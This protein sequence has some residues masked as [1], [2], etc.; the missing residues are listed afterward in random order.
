MPQSRR[1]FGLKLAGA[2]FTALFLATIFVLMWMTAHYRAE[3]DWTT[4]GRNSLSAPSVALLRRLHRPV[5][6]RA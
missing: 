1:R 6:I 4:T 3:F 2:S 5:E